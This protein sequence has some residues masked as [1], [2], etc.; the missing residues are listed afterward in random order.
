MKPGIKII[1]HGEQYVD[2]SELMEC[3]MCKCVFLV[4]DKYA[5]E[6]KIKQ[7]EFD[8]SRHFT[9]IECPECGYPIEL[10]KK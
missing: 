1:K 5:I 10:E 8:P 6:T 3:C 7:D 4:Q 9:A 2:N